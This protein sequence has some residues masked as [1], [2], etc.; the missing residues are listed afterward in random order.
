MSRAGCSGWRRCGRYRRDA[1]RWAGVF[2]APEQLVDWAAFGV[3]GGDGLG[4]GVAVGE[5]VVHHVAPEFQSRDVRFGAACPGAAEVEHRR[6]SPVVVRFV[7]RHEQQV[8]GVQ[9]IMRQPRL[10]E[11]REVAGVRLERRCEEVGVGG[12][13]DAPPGAGDEG[14][15][16]GGPLRPA[17]TLPCEGRVSRF[18]GMLGRVWLWF[19]SPCGGRG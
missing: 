8:V 13:G 16:M 15:E 10:G 3:V 18:S 14:R 2:E 9:V 7:A 12:I 19:P 1:V 17:A 6:E 11:V 4:C 5:A